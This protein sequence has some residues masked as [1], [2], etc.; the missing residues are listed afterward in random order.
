MAAKRG[1]KLMLTARNEE[2]LGKLAEELNTQGGN[3]RYVAADAASEADMIMVAAET[4]SSFGNFDTWI[5]N[6]GVSIY[7][8]LEEIPDADS[9]QLFDTNF[10]GVVNGSLTAAKHLK[11]FG[12]AIINIG[13][14]LSDRAIPIQGMYCA[15]KHAVKGFTDALRMELEHDNAPIS[16]TLIKP[17]AIDTPYKEHA[18]NYLGVQPENPPP[19]YSPETVAETILHCAENPVRDCFVGGGGKAMSVMGKFAPRV[20]DY[21]MENSMFEMQRSDK[22][23][24]GKNVEGLYDTRDSRLKER[25]GYE[26]HVA[27]SS[28]YTKASLHPLTT[29]AAFAVGIGA[30]FLAVRELM[31]HLDS[32]S[33]PAAKSARNS[34]RNKIASAEKK[35]PGATYAA[36]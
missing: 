35:H 12:G 23:T 30:V 10:W 22:K 1:A 7:G 2:A 17:S 31:R 11:Q 16:V 28:M 3:V 26:G 6:A 8:K 34:L 36:T 29:G 4:L 18:K 5:N 19:V 24:N 21:V 32:D 15:S 14:T 20:T 33:D 13:S 27:E 25:G 9:R